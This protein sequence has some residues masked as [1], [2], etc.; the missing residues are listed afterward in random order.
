MTIQTADL[1]DE[2]IEKLQ[3]VRCG[4]KP[5]GGIESFNGPIETLRVFEDNS[6][7]A[8]TV[9]TPGEGRI[10]VVDGGGS[11]RCAL[12]GDR[13]AQKACDNGWKG[14]IIHGAIRDAKII[15]KM[16]LGV[17]ALETTPRKSI[18]QNRG[19]RGVE[20][21]FLGTRFAPGMHIYCDFDGIVLSDSALF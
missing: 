8:E 20:L 10:L 14:I 6:K 21:G 19:E 12:L 11:T 3:V 2:F 13:L 4:L 5:Y 7:V 18:K 15:S 9:A 16:P 17:R 1:C